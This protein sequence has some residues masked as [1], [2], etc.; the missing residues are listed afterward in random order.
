VPFR[1]LTTDLA[2]KTKAPD[3]DAWK[4]SHVPGDPPIE[5]GHRAL[6][7]LADIPNRSDIPNRHRKR[8]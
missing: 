6:G 4:I 1:S 3:K 5:A 8:T 7:L 2:P